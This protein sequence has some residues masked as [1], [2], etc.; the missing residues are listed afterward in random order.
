MRW[1]ECGGHIRA[2]AR[3][4]IIL[5][6]AGL[7]AC[8]FEPLYG[9]HPS[10]GEESIRDKLGEVLIAPIPVRQGTPQARAAVALRNALQFNLNGAAG[11]TAPTHRLEVILTTPV[12]IT[13]SS[14]PVAGRPTEEIGGLTAIYQLIEIAT[15]KV[16][17]KDSTTT[18]VGYDIPGSQQRFAKQRAMLD[19]EERAAN[20]AAE[21]IRNRLASYFVAGS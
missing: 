5:S 9:R 14:D 2:L 8:G 6:T 10:S 18:H 15:G 7:F 16:V 17:L 4:G 12:N 20:V 11:A 3:V 19:A 1:S 21:A 13:V